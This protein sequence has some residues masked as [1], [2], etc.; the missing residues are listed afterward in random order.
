MFKRNGKEVGE[1]RDPMQEF[2]DR[3]VGELEK[4]VKPWVRPWDASKCSGP[5][6]PRN[7][8]TGHRYSGIN[9]LVLGMHPAAFQTAD[10]RFATY[11]QAK[12]HG[13]QVRKGERSTP[14]FFY[15]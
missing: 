15:K 5:Q 8:A 7:A 14:V 13:W 9:V 12:E 6:A 2:A 11:L 10:P 3:I 1:H 4:G